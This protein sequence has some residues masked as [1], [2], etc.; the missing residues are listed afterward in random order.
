MNTSIGHT[1][2]NSLS[3]MVLRVF[4]L[5]NNDRKGWKTSYMREEKE[6]RVDHLFRTRWFLNSP[7]GTIHFVFHIRT[8]AIPAPGPN[9]TSN[10][11]WK[12]KTGFDRGIL[13]LA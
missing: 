8:L 3:Q 6:T 2:P 4:C 1:R 7:Q 11:F 10:Y 12:N 9:S 5:Q 13:Q